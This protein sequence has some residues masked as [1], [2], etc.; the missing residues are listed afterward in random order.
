LRLLLGQAL[1]VNGQL[2]AS[3]S[4]LRRLLAVAPDHREAAL[5]LAFCLRDHG[6]I[7]AAAQVILDWFRRAPR[8]D[9]ETLAFARF[10]AEL[11][12]FATA[13]EVLEQPAERSAQAAAATELAEAYRD[14]MRQD[15]EPSTFYL[16]KNPLNLMWAD[17]ARA[18]LPGA[19]VLC[20]RR[21]PRAVALSLWSNQFAHPAMA[22]SYDFAQI[23]IFLRGYQRLAAA[24][25]DALPANQFRSVTYADLVQGGD[26]IIAGLWHWLDLDPAEAL[27]ASSQQQGVTTASVFQVREPTHQRSLERWRNYANL[28]PELAE[29]SDGT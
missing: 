18:L 16:D 7:Q 20:L 24:M 27:P 19:R 28:V 12:A 17:V 11:R 8:A 14:Q 22:F 25:A 13:R 26:S 3:A 23:G 21:D 9:A 29:M 10:L 2:A 5:T 4:E 6:R 1:R 15:D